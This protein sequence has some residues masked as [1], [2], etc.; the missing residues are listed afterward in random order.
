MRRFLLSVTLVLV[1]VSGLHARGLVIPVDKSIPP[2]AMLNH[3]VDV[4]IEDQVA[5]T[6]I[7]QTFRNHTSRQ[8]EAT[9]VFPVPRGA[10]VREFAMWV[11]GK[12]VK[13]ELLEAAKARQIYTDIVRRSQDPGLLEYIGHDVLKM[14]IFPVPPNGDQKIEVSYTSLARKDQDIIEYTYPLKTDGKTLSTLD[15]FTLKLSL[16][17]QHP[18]VN[19]YS[20]THAISINR[21][22]DKEAVVGFEKSQS[23]LDRDFQLFW[24]TSGKDVGLTALMHRPISTENGYALLLISPRAELVKQQQVPRDMVFV[25]DT[26]GSMREDGKMEQ[27]RKALKHCLDGLREIDRFAVLNFAT[28]VNRQREGLTPVTSEHIAAAKKWIDNLEPSGG[29]AINDALLAALDLQSKEA[30]RTFTVVFFTDGKPTIGE[31]NPDK[32]LANVGKRNTAQT[33]VFAFGVGNDLNAAFLDQLADSTRAASSFVRPQEDMEAKV[34]SF[35]DKISRP[36]LANLKLTTS[37]GVSLSEVYPP[38]LPDLFHGGQVVVLARYSGSSHAALVLAGTIG[39]EQKEY[40]FELDFAARAEDKPFVEELWARRKVGYLLEQIRLNGEKKE[41]VDET[42]A[43]A[44]KYG[45]ATPYTSYLVVP[46]APTP[47]AGGGPGMP[48]AERP[49]AG[50]FNFWSAPALRPGGLGGAPGVAANEP[51]KVAELAKEVKEQNRGVAEARSRFEDQKLARAAENVGKP[52]QASADRVLAETL[53]RKKSLELAQDAFR[54]RDVRF[55]QQDKL[56]VDLSV[57]V[58]KLKGESRQQHSAARRIANRQLIEIGG[59]W[60][61]DGYDPKM[62]TLIVKALSDGYFKLLERQPQVKEVLQLGNHL[63]WVAPSGTALVID[64]NDGK[65]QLTDA[66]VDQLF[67]TR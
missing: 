52:N 14:H 48:R 36:V 34:S 50:N 18:I 55:V 12:R 6:K 22:G 64:L 10:S 49:D 54:Q 56:G 39:T 38:N 9:Y 21:T 40:V 59:V 2:L 7:E 33:R 24:T 30:G 1:Y 44:K 26:S 43:L 25:L 5:I 29:T 17:S 57:Q 31:T 47:V 65:E 8:L 19:I 45:I 3:R 46:D 53:E 28:V 15:D 58:G 51:R 27:A 62:P 66:E 32:I 11:D 4:A 37:G 63:V 42:V 16:K 20:P 60:I 35:F 41:L 61:D 13:G 67:K 23:L